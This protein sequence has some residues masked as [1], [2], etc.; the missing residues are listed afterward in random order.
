MNKGSILKRFLY[1]LLAFLILIIIQGPTIYLGVKDASL[2][3][4]SFSL[5]S[6]ERRSSFLGKTLGSS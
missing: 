4:L 5:T 2:V 1:L 6:Q 3:S